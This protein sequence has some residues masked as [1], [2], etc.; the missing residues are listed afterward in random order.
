MEGEGRMERKE[1]LSRPELF[2]HSGHLT[3]AISWIKKTR[4]TGEQNQEPKLAR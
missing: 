2:E 4:G 3:K 1:A